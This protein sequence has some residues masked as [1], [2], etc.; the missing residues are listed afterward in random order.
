MR[1][2]LP[3]SAS[4]VLRTFAHS[5]LD[6]PFLHKRQHLPACACARLG[7]APAAAALLPPEVDGGH[8]V[9]ITAVCDD[10]AGDV[11]DDDEDD[12]GREDYGR[13]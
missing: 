8:N 13:L 6:L 1:I 10:V 9:I 3:N 5:K 2:D 4:K 11:D 7:W 12:H